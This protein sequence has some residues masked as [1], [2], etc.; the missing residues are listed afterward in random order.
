MFQNLIAQPLFGYQWQVKQEICITQLQLHVCLQVNTYQCFVTKGFHCLCSAVYVG[1]MPR[2]QIQ[3][4]VFLDLGV[5]LSMSS[6][7]L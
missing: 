6:I 3:S 4:H 2:N 1:L 7:F 5:Q